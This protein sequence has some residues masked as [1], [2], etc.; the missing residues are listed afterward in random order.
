MS[1]GC[2]L[3]S[4]PMNTRVQDTM[5][6]NHTGPECL[7]DQA[8]DTK[9]DRVCTRVLQEHHSFTRQI[10]QCRLKHTRCAA[11]ACS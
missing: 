2:Q 8:S 11:S 10:P 5:T 3:A 6:P 9:P 1:P 4:R 7:G